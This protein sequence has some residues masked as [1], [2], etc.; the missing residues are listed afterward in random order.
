[1]KF[2]E[3][4]LDSLRNNGRLET[5]SA[6]APLLPPNSGDVKQL[7]NR[8]IRELR[9][10]RKSPK[11]FP[12]S[13]MAFSPPPSAKPGDRICRSCAMPTRFHKDPKQRRK[14]LK[15]MQDKYYA[16]L[17]WQHAD[18]SDRYSRTRAAVAARRRAYLARKANE[19]PERM[20]R[21]IT[22]STLFD[23]LDRKYP[24][25]RSYPSDSKRYRKGLPPR[26]LSLPAT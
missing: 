18:P 11:E 5:W 23:I 4:I 12:S 25:R 1:M 20:R 8:Y 15:R 7:L 10:V 19:L 14:C 24:A 6:I 21:T 22:A 16:D 2:N 17:Y 13:P 9:P 26:T 3:L